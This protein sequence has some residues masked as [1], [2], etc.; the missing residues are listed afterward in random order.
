[1]RFQ[2][3]DTVFENF[4]ELESNR[5]LYRNFNAGDAADLFY[6]KTDARVMAHMDSNK[7]ESINDSLEAIKRNQDSF[8]DKTGINWAIVDKATNEFIGYFGY[9][10]FF[11]ENCRGEIGYS[12]KPEFWGK[13]FM[14]EAMTRLIAFGF[15][16]LNLHS[17]EAN[18]NPNN[19]NSEKLLVNF[20]FKKEAHFRENY[21]FNG[22]F[23]D[24]IIYC[25]LESD[26]K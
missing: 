20:G 7:H 14:T 16:D 24:S 4:P 26:L 15:E 6:L 2:I 9:W 3:N 8:K 18:I 17:I 21:L 10:R 25:L 13:G 11:R 23:L 19:A 5:L 12:L 1:M 22:Q